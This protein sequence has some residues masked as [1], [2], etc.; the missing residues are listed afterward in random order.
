MS[1][2]VQKIPS[3]LESGGAA[4]PAGIFSRGANMG[5]YESWIRRP[6]GAIILISHGSHSHDLAAI[7]A[8]QKLRRDGELVE[9]WRD[10]SCVYSERPGSTAELV[11]PIHDR[12]ANA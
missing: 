1:A 12:A 10:G 4:I 8:A 9:V 11:W 2:S 3:T 6:T 5:Q 7:R